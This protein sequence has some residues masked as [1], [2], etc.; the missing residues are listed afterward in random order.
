MLPDY[1]KESFCVFALH[2]TEHADANV[3]DGGVTRI[4]DGTIKLWLFE[5]VLSIKR[6]YHTLFIFDARCQQHADGEPGAY[7]TV[8]G[9][10]VRRRGQFVFANVCARSQGSVIPLF[11]WKL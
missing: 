5:L 8:T 11:G 4:T 10:A 9:R 3:P 2:Q 1:D 7:F 6:V